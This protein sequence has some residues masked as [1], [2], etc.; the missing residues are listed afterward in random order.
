FARRTLVR[1]LEAIADDVAR[2]LEPLCGRGFRELPDGGKQAALDAVGRTFEAGGPSGGGVFAPRPGPAKPPPHP[3]AGG[4]PAAGGPGGGGG[5]GGGGTEFFPLGLAAGAACFVGVVVAL[6]PF[7]ARASVET[8]RR[9]SA[10]DG[11]IAEVLARLPRPRLDAP[12]GTGLD[13]DFR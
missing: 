13:D 4:G 3:R 7:D 11:G 12:A 1:Q 10:L 5:G 2:R 8:L 6:P 9:L